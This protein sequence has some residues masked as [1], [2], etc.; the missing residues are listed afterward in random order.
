MTEKSYR[1]LITGGSDGIGLAL[2]RKLL[3]NGHQVLITGRDV[4]RLHSAVA[5]NP[6]LKAL[7]SDVTKKTDRHELGN[8]IQSQ[9]E[10]I[11]I[12][13][14]NAGIGHGY[15]FLSDEGADRFQQEIQ[16]NL[17]AP[18]L[19]IHE[20][21]HLLERP[22]VIMNITSGY[23]LFPGPCLPG[24]SASKSGLSAFTSVLQ[25]QSTLQKENLHVFEVCPPMVETNMTQSVDCFKISAERVANEI[26]HAIERKPRRLL[27]GLCRLLELSA[28]ISPGFTRWFIRGWPISV[29]SL[30]PYR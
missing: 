20:L 21:R 6:G 1:I 28:R 19:L 5:S 12:L 27:I 25:V 23:A 14:N 10:K 26:V 9:F 11:D 17:V 29:H 3:S 15:Y 7:R 13:I 2:A 4:G 24:Y 16:T 18:V 22:G 30:A 8:F